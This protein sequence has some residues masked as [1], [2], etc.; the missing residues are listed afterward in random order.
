MERTPLEGF[1]FIND[2]QL[3]TAFGNLITA[4]FLGVLDFSPNILG[5]FEP[6]SKSQEDLL[7]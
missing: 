6:W 2:S 1:C 7:N 3:I 5:L 4:I